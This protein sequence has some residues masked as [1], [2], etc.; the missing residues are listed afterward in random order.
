MGAG[1][2]GAARRLTGEA[3][4]FA[5]YFKP[6]KFSRSDFWPLFI[7]GKSGKKKRVTPQA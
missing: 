4:R 6:Q 5:L 1:S 2:K 7:A 3:A